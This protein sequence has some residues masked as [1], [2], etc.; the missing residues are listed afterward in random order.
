MKA[1][2]FGVIVFE[3]D[4][5]LTHEQVY[6]CYADR[7]QLELVFD[8]YKNDE[9]LDKTGVQ[10][11]FS[12]FGM[13]FINFIAT[14]AT[15]RILKKA[16][17]AGLLNE[18]SYGDM[19]DDLSEA[20]RKTDAPEVPKSDDGYWIHT[21]RPAIEEMEKL[22][23]LEPAISHEKRKRG[24]PKKQIMEAKPKRPRGRPRKNS[25]GSANTALS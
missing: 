15:C 13:E 18:M 25:I 14:L 2:T 12:V 24:R 23:L 19:M 7:W 22:G 9:C 6:A 10:G 3:S 8:S 11:D 16:R 21:L 20:W 4:L 5:E 1:K 17:V